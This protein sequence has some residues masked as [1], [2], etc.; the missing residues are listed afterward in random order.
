M[1]WTTAVGFCLSPLFGRSTAR[2]YSEA[3]VCVVV[4]DDKVSNQTSREIKISSLGLSLGVVSAQAHGQNSGFDFSPE[5]SVSISVSRI[6]SRVSKVWCR[7][8]SLVVVR[9][10]RRL[11]VAD[12]LLHH[13][14]RPARRPAAR[15][16]RLR[17]R[18]HLHG[19]LR[20]RQGCQRPRRRRARRRRRRRRRRSSAGRDRVDAA[21]AVRGQ[22]DRR[23]GVRGR[24]A[25]VVHSAAVL[26]RRAGRSALRR[27]GARLDAQHRRTALLVDVA[28]D[29]QLVLEVRRLRRLLSRLSYWT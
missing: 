9:L 8:T 13:S 18:L 6:C 24:L 15:R 1:V 21:G 11:V 29:R 17:Q 5:V 10:C 7:L 20:A 25:A 16:A 28:R 26:L 19:D 23:L 3:Y 2:Y 27:R 22:R 14:R 4:R 12:G